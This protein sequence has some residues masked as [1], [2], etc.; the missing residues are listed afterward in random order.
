MARILKSDAYTR[1][2]ELSATYGGGSRWLDA[3][4]VVAVFEDSHIGLHRLVDGQHLDDAHQFALTVHE[5][6]A[7]IEA[8]TA[9]LAMREAAGSQDDFGDDHPF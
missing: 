2:V 5:M 7:L 3:Q 6:T 1:Y 8:Y 9:F 4:Q